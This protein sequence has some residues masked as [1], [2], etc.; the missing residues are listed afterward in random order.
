MKIMQYVGR[1]LL[2]I[3]AI[4]FGITHVLHAGMMALIAPFGG[5]IIVYVT[6]ICLLLA[7]VSLVTGYQLRIASLLLGILL[8]II[9]L[10]LHLPGI[11]NA[12]DEGSKLMSSSNLMK[13]LGLAG[14]A[15]FMA[16]TYWKKPSGTIV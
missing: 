9:A 10:T 5:K 8:L 12:M 3:T 13:D 14:A 1:I 15:F 4:S 7:A 16:G 2:A 6:G 11:I